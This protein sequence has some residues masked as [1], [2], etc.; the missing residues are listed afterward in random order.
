MD[1]RSI[2]RHRYIRIRTKFFETAATRFGQKTLI[3]ALL[4]NFKIDNIFCQYTCPTSFCYQNIIVAR[5]PARYLLGT[6]LAGFSM[7]HKF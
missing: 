4:K 6:G 1:D 2:M 3:I 7:E 5:Y